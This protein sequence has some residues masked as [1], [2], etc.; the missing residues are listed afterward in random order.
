[1]GGDRT[2]ARV[3]ADERSAT[4]RDPRR[5]SGHHVMIA[6]PVIPLVVADRADHG[7]LVGDARQPRHDLRVVDAGDLRPD[8]AELAANLGR[9]VRL[10][11]EGLVMRR[12]AVHPD[13]DAAARRRSL[14]ARR[15]A[16]ADEI[17]EAGPGESA[18]AELQGVATRQHHVEV[19][20]NPSSRTRAC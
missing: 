4:D 15:G 1:M 5:R 3:K 8:H 2:H 9:R 6:G 11:V 17:G 12:P 10:G 20:V 14:G 18:Q 13:E 7:R 16:E 19:S